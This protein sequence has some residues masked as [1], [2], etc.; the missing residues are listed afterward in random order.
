MLS[1]PE[2]R[3]LH[4][5][6]RTIAESDPRLATLLS[7]PPRGSGRGARIAHD[8]VCVLSAL[9]GVLC[10]VLGQV[11]PGLAAVLFAGVVLES[12]RLRFPPTAKPRSPV[13]RRTT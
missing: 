4:E 12:R 5:I 3:L 13:E 8:I 7:A 2:Q 10:L 11:G 6:E 1:G 9:L